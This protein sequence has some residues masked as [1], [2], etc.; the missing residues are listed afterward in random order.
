MRPLTSVQISTRSTS[1]AAPSS[2]AVKSEPPRPSVVGVPSTVAP[3]KPWV[4]GI[5]PAS[6]SGRR[7]SRA[8]A[9]SA[10]M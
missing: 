5:R 7:H 1:S 8:R 4:T 2:A 6:T 3:M 9:V 10:C